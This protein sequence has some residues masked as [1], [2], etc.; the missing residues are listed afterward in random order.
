[1]PHLSRVSSINLTMLDSKKKRG[2]IGQ[3]EQHST[4]DY[5]PDYGLFE[6]SRIAC[7]VLPQYHP[8]QLMELL[9]SGKIRWVKAI[10]AHLVRCISST[11]AFRQGSGLQSSTDEE[12]LVRQRGWSRSRTLSVS[13]AG[14]G[15]TSPLEH[16]GS[17][18]AIPEEVTLDYAEIASI[19]PLPLYTLLA[20]DRETTSNVATSSGTGPNAC[21]GGSTNKTG[22][23]DEDNYGE[24]FDSTLNGQDES[25]DQLLCDE[26][27]SPRRHERRQSISQE[28]QGLSHFGPR[29]GRLLSRLL[30]HTHLPGLSSLDQM[31][32]LALADTVSTCNTDFAERFA[33]DAAKTA[34]AKENLTG[35]PDSE[36]ISTGKIIIILHNISLL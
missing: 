8:K 32:L 7:P 25:L 26:P 1:M 20:A 30:T 28:R 12:T 33:I 19:P 14:A 22:A 17:T 16:R 9:N 4:L 23:A 31:H 10:L 34:I 18:T 5:M 35:L 27:D 11:Y 6:A 21:S 29:Q 2:A 15:T 13:Y 24:L 36:D 3:Q